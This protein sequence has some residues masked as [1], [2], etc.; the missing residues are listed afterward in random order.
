MCFQIKSAEWKTKQLE[1]K[2]NSCSIVWA[3]ESCCAGSQIPSLQFQF[4]EQINLIYYYHY[5]YYYY[6]EKSVLNTQSK[7]CNIYILL[8]GI[9]CL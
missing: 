4:H 8:V 2:E 7:I 9:L 5:Y 6:Y 3:S 1:S